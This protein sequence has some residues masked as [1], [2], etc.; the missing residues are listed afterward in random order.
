MS[1]F[2]WTTSPH[3][4]ARMAWTVLRVL[5]VSAI[6]SGV[7]SRIDFFRSTPVV[8]PVHELGSDCYRLGVVWPVLNLSLV[9]FLVI[10][11]GA[12]W[13]WRRQQV[14]HNSGAR[15]LLKYKDNR[16]RM[17]MAAT[18]V[19]TVGI[20][21]ATNAA[22]ASGLGFE[23]AYWQSQQV[24]W[25]YLCLAHALLG[26]HWTVA[27]AVLVQLLASS[28]V[29]PFFAFFTG[30]HIYEPLLATTHSR[31]VLAAA[32]VSAVAA[33]VLLST[34]RRGT[35]LPADS[36]ESRHELA[37]VEEYRTPLSR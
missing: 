15:A 21:I 18:I 20:G 27:V 22:V 25:G 1:G 5:G 35:F 12:G 31:S 34:H 13:W 17:G 14:D 30:Q 4:A 8:C 33:L 2:L 11:G 10:G 9:V 3:W 32:V 26:A 7:L 6:F 29:E 36:G 24:F 19:S 28:L 16:R 23:Q 37:E